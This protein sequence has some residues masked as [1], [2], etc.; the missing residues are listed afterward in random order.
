MRGVPVRRLSRQQEQL[1]EWSGVCGNMRIARAPDAIGA[2]SRASISVGRV[3]MRVNNLPKHFLN[4]DLIA[5]IAEKV[6]F[7][8]R[9]SVCE[10]QTFS[11]ML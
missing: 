1:P 7:F 9:N 5:L 6:F 4:I 3:A 2:V 11:K 8:S 10:M